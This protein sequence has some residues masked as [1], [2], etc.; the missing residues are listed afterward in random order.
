MTIIVD[1]P[2]KTGAV[3]AREEFCSLI[4]ENGANRRYTLVLYQEDGS[5]KREVREESGIGTV[6]AE[7]NSDGWE[8]AFRDDASFP[9]TMIFFKRPMRRHL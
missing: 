1:L 8:F 4:L 3:M 5:T 9:V 7:L 6:I 2:P